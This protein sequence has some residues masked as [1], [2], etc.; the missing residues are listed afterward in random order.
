MATPLDRIRAQSG[1]T[2]AQ[3]FSAS[4]ATPVDGSPLVQPAARRPMSHAAGDVGA[5]ARARRGAPV[6]LTGL[7]AAAIVA[8]VLATGVA[9]LHRWTLGWAS[10]RFD[11]GGLFVFDW[12]TSI[13]TFWQAHRWVPFV[14]AA[15]ALGVVVLAVVTDGFERGGTVESIGTSVAIGVG[16]TLSVPLLVV[17]VLGVVTLVVYVAIVAAMVAAGLMVLWAIASS[18]LD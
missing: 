6:D 7:R 1:L 14:A 18:A 2:S 17:F 4:P 5:V 16:S 15:V 3:T 9:V 12:M 11:D 10:G 8:G 13:L